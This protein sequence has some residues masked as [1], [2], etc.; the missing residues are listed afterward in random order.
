MNEKETEN[1]VGLDGGGGF[2]VATPKDSNW[3]R[4]K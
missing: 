4:R 3:Q 2:A 1:T